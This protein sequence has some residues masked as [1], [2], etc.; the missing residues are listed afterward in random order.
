MSLKARLNH[1]ENGQRYEFGQWEAPWFVV[2]NDDDQACADAEVERWR[3]EIERDKARG[4]TT[5]GFNFR[6]PDPTPDETYSI[7]SE[8]SKKPHIEAAVATAFEQ[9]RR[10]RGRTW[11]T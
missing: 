1:L 9:E 11:A 2:R 3:E 6:D 7:G 10:A 5:F 8:L 4:R